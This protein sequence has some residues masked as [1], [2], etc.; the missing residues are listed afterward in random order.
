M[1]SFMT[2]FWVKYEDQY[3]DERSEDAFGDIL[4]RYE[5]LKYSDGSVPDKAIVTESV[6]LIFALSWLPKA[7]EQG[8]I[9]DVYWFGLANAPLQNK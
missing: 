5:S 2:N 1:E 3:P 7:V 9:K 6:S 4:V 8:L